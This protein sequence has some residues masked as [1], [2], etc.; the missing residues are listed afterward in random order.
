MRL[1]LWLS[2]ALVASHC[3]SANAAVLDEKELAAARK[4]TVRKCTKCHKFYEPASYTPSDW[5]QW[6]DRMARKSKLSAA[7]ERQIRSYLST[8]PPPR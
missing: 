8:L 3:L 5:N 4:L 2:A 6:M 7:Q 1:A